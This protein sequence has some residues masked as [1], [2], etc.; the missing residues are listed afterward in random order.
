M[1]PCHASRLTQCSY[2]KE[3]ADRLNTLESHLV[4]PQAQN[5]DFNIE[6]TMQPAPAVSSP[7]KRTHS[8]SENFTDMY[9][10]PNWDQP[11]NG[12]PPISNRR[13]SFGETALAGDL[14]A[15]SNEGTIKAYY[16]S[17]H[18]TLP[19]LPQDLSSLN[20][21]THCPAKLREALF[22]ALECS[23]RSLGTRA[24]SA[25]EPTVVQ[26][27]HQCNEAVDAARHNY[28]D[29]DST[30]HFFNGLVYC[31][32]LLFLVIASD[33]PT[34]GMVGNTSEL[35]SRVS[36]CFQD[37]GINDAKVLAALRDQDTE[38]Y[39]AARRTFWVALM[40]DRFHATSRSRDIVLPLYPGRL[41]RADYNMLGETSF[42]LAR[43][44]DIVGQVAFITK[45][46]SVLS[47]DGSVVLCTPV[48]LTGEINRYLESLDISD[49]PPNSTPYLACQYLRLFVARQSDQTSS[50]Q[51]LSLTKELLSN[52]MSGSISPVHHIFASLVATSL[53]DMA[54]RVETQVEAHASIKEMT[55]GLANGHILHRSFDNLGWDIAI[56]DL[57]TQKKNPSSPVP[58]PEHTGPA[59]Q[60]NMAGLQHLA[61]AAVGEREGSESKPTSRGG[62]GLA[63]SNLSEPSDNDLTAAMK[64][65][66]EAAQAQA[67]AAAAQQQLQGTPRNGG[68]S[69]FD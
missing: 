49:L 25:N 43:A 68:E 34:S 3:L 15:G 61:A 6:H 45:A 56:R 18:P 19:L 44:A 21:L 62:D 26:S 40:L 30:Q 69:S 39:E 59:A 22:L 17:I 35:L 51:I 23:V 42:H 12:G 66:S 20:R 13:V 1:R 8:I 54:D 10:R 65:A 29:P 57:L 41:T 47:N 27:I 58:L 7:R 28:S 67:T 32:S 37:V 63:T 50:T 2:I 11:L 46:E 48:Y 60:P 64:A 38:T 33:R 24:V 55:D 9:A 52:L 31:Q 16:N 5:Y 53:A 4:Q 14:I 36:G